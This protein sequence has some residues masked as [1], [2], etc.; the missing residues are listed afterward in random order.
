MYFNKKFF[1]IL[2]CS[3]RNSDLSLWYNKKVKSISQ[4][5]CRVEKAYKPLT[6]SMRCNFEISHLLLEG[7]LKL[8]NT[9]LIES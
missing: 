7:C 5:A 9:F 2:I 4:Q 3:C 8:D 6:R 1:L